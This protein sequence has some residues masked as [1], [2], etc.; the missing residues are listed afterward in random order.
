MKPESKVFDSHPEVI[1]V[2]KENQD[3]DPDWVFKPERI[4]SGWV[5]RVFDERKND[6]GFLW[7]PLKT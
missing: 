2:A 5:I 4:L 3:R 1:R 7:N 6:I